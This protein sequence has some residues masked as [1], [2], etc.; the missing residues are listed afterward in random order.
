MISQIICFIII[1]LCAGAVNLLISEPFQRTLREEIISFLG[2]VV[3]G[4]ATF[5]AL[6]VVISVLFQ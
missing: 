2:V 5:T 6:V 4:I 3:G 1:T